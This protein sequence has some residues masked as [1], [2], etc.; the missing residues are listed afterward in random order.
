MQTKDVFSNAGL[1]LLSMAL[2]LPVTS[3]AQSVI[4]PANPTPNQA[5]LAAHLQ[6]VCTQLAAAAN[7]ASGLTAPQQDLLSSCRLFV[8]PQTPGATL[9]AAYKAVLG[10]QINAL[11][12]QTKKFGSLQ[13]DNLAARL[14]ELR[15]GVRGSKT[16]GLVLR[17][18]DG[19]L[20]ASSGN[21]GDYLPGGGS[22][23]GNLQFLD[24]RLGVFINGSV[25]VGSKGASKNSYSY[26]FV[27]PELTYTHGN[28]LVAVRASS[29]FYNITLPDVE[30]ITRRDNRPVVE[31]NEYRVSEFS[32]AV[33][34][35]L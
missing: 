24:G 20:S 25:K 34:V 21:L 13:Q 35:K 22:G 8:D 18:D 2:H 5:S 17:S 31:R 10:Q 29:T 23:D 30:E 3:H 12:P 14:A 27:Q 19:P 1:L 32:V 7:G 15:R 28:V 11:G 4:L 6:N 26:S 33:G 16:A 9:A